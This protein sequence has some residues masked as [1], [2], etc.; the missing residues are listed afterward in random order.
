M[1]MQTEWRSDGQ[2]LV[3]AS[4]TTVSK[5]G[6]IAVEIAVGGGGPQTLTPTSVIS[7]ESFGTSLLTLFLDVSSLGT[8]EQHGT[9]KLNLKLEIN[10]IGSEESIGTSVIQAGIV[11]L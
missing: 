9:S 5:W 10:S 1:G 8:G 4:W 3:D 2:T 6:S 11:I 7:V